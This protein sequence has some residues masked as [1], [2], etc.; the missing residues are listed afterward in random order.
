M[1][2]SSHDT[3]TVPVVVL[4]VANTFT[5]IAYSDGNVKKSIE[6]S[7]NF[8]LPKVFERSCHHGLCHHTVKVRTRF[9]QVPYER[10]SN[11]ISFGD[12]IRNCHISEAIG[13]QHVVFLQARESTCFS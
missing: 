13:I 11:D 6:I 8:A 4:M 5:T 1:I 7:A 10:R 3:G 12:S 9:L 2:F